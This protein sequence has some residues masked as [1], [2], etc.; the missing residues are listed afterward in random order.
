MV[1]Q[2]A[3]AEL[4]ERDHDHARLR[5]AVALADLAFRHREALLD[6]GVGEV[7]ELP[8]DLLDRERA[9]DV[10]E[11]DAQHLLVAEAA[12]LGQLALDVAFG[13]RGEALR[14]IEAQV[15][16]LADQRRRAAVDELVDQLRMAEQAAAQEIA[17]AEEGDEQAR[18]ARALREQVGGRGR[19]GELAEEVGEVAQ[20]LVGVGRRRQLLHQRGAGLVV[21]RIGRERRAALAGEARQLLR[22]RV[23]LVEPQLGQR[24]G[25]LLV[26]RVRVGG[27][28]RVRV[29]AGRAFAGDAQQV[30]EARLDVRPV[31]REVGE[32]RLG[33]GISRPPRQPRLLE[34]V[35]GDGVRLP[36][37]HHL[38]AV[39]EPAQRDVGLRQLVAIAA[40]DE[41]GV[42]QPLQGLQGPAHAQ[43]RVAAAVEELQ[44]LDEELDLAD[45][46]LA[47]LEIDAGSARGVL[48]GARLEPA[49]LVDRL[50][51]EVLPEDERRE[52]PQ[53]LLAGR[54][55][56]PRSAAP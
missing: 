49:H 17:R 6:A 55:D 13:Q 7:G 18:G 44:R 48:L 56:R 22:A 11:A 10:V 31:L 4:A 2:L 38:H 40:G 32:H 21:R 15:V 5:A 29:L 34:R 37:G 26:A 9:G 1:A 28:D 3:P 8:R 24:R 20:G 12:Q 42:E 52:P 14:E 36:L 51:V 30:L 50:E 35:L 33:V 41:A 25:A 46:A 45:A 23:G 27:G 54:Q 19:V 47:E 39:L 53:R 16:A 43:V